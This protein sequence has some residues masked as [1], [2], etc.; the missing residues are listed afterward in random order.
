[1]A[2]GEIRRWV[3]ALPVAELFTL[4]DVQDAFPFKSREAVKM[5]MSRLCRGD[6]PLVARAVRG[7]YC[8]RLLGLRRRV[9]IPVEAREALRW[10]IAGPGAGLTG[11]DLMNQIGWSTQVS[12]RRWIAVVGRPPQAPDG[13]T[14]YKERLNEKRAG[15]NRWEVSLLEAARCF[16]EWAELD[17]SEAVEKYG[18][19]RDKGFYGLPVRG[20]ALLE[21]ADSERGLRPQ[22]V[23][24]CRNLVT[25]A[26]TSPGLARVA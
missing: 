6:D 19:N 2:Y 12:P 7:I 16:D 25:V 3:E 11:P 15:L 5:T 21:A 22:F 13:A 24:R 1:M 4:D 20:S 14:I 26:E 23:E 17:W 18:E 8:R 9:P 10:R